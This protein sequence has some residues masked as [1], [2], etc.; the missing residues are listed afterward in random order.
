[1]LTIAHRL[2]TAITYS[3]RIVVMDQG[4]VAEEGHSF[5]LLMDN[6]EDFGKGVKPPKTPE[7]DTIFASMVK[8]LP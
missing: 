4:H 8:V 3:D 1:M 6:P 5:E 2:E 7:R